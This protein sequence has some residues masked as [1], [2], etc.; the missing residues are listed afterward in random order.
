LTRGGARCIPV[1]KAL[2]NEERGEQRGK[3]RLAGD[4]G[5]RGVSKQPRGWKAGPPAKRGTPEIHRG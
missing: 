5:G 3:R 2:P 1:E 4:V